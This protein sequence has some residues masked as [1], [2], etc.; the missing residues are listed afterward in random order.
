MLSSEK[1]AGASDAPRPWWGSFALE[2]GESRSW[3]IGPLLLCVT[4]S[5]RE[6]RILAHRG[7]D[8]HADA[9]HVFRECEPG[10]VP[11]AA[12]VHRFGFGKTN[13]TIA[14]R[15]LLPDLPVIVTP[16]APFTLPQGEEVRVFVSTP[17]WFEIRLGEPEKPVLEEPIH[18]PKETWFGP[19]TREGELCY[20]DRT[21]VRL[22]H[23]TLPARPQRSVSPVRIVN[24]A[25]TNLALDRIRLPAPNLSLFERG[26]FLWTEAVTFNRDA[27]GES[28]EISLSEGAPSEA[29]GGRRVAEPRKA[30]RK[31]LF[32]RTFGQIFD[33]D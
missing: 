27:D 26:S 32:T 21:S 8:P 3:R 13:G 25:R 1:L 19:S 5:A 2:T 16:T 7:A 11:A 30:A 20:A 10:E 9:L 4:R 22:A 14:I 33:F 17:L 18:R 6:W 23:E 28:A 24:R 31:G 12:R 29:A 15:P